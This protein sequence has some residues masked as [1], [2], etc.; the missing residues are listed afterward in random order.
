ME[1]IRQ[2][3]ELDQYVEW[4]NPNGEIV[5]IPRTEAANK[6]YQLILDRSPFDPA[7]LVDRV[8]RIEILEQIQDGSNKDQFYMDTQWLFAKVI[9]VSISMK[10]SYCDIEVSLSK[11]SPLIVSQALPLK[12]PEEY[13]NTF[14]TTGTDDEAYLNWLGLT[15][16]YTSKDSPI[17][18]SAQISSPRYKDVFDDVDVMVQIQS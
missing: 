12:Y 17:K 15:F 18:W 9:G 16:D 2:P 8:L 10:Y 13:P 1:E 14:S 11:Y 5:S 7:R 6:V 3:I 4:E